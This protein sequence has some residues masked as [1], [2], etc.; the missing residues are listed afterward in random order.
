MSKPEHAPLL[1]VGTPHSRSS[2]IASLIGLFSIF[3]GGIGF[4]RFSIISEK[5]TTIPSGVPHLATGLICGFLAV[6]L[7][8][9]Q[10]SSPKHPLPIPVVP[11]ALTI[12]TAYCLAAAIECSFIPFPDAASADPGFW[13]A[14]LEDMIDQDSC[15]VWIIVSACLLFLLGLSVLHWISPLLRAPSCGTASTP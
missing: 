11:L 4:H 7:I 14:G 12:P 13:D 10:R 15:V 6:V 8:I 1:S 2:M 3:C 9:R 5:L